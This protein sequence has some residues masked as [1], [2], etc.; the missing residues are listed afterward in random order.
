MQHKYNGETMNGIEDHNG[1][2][3]ETLAEGYKKIDRRKVNPELFD[4]LETIQSEGKALKVL[5]IGCGAG[6]DA[7]IIA[8]MGHNVV[9]VEPSDLRDIA[10]RDHSH[11]KIRYV[12]GRLPLL[13]HIL[14]EPEIF[15][16]V[17][18]SAVYQY[19]HPEDR[20]QSIWQIGSI[21]KEGGRIF[22]NYPSPP[23]RPYQYEIT[24][25]QLRHDIRQANQ[26]LEGPAILSDTF[27]ITAI[28]DS[29]GRQSLDGRELNFYNCE[30]K[31][32]C[33]ANRI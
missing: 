25:G 2:N 27:R 29:R 26:H 17:I 10:E 22:L 12:E 11:P 24:P 7:I 6:N 5:D 31:K 18:L 19:I 9:G 30:I 4:Y 32:C 33:P 8:K 1:A 20:V 16:V 23:S 13:P 28:P 14:Q 3:A 21:L 15:D